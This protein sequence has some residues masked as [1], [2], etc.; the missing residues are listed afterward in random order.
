MQ[1][2]ARR[3]AQP[4]GVILKATRDT[5]V[6]AEWQR[7]KAQYSARSAWLRIPF[8]GSL[9]FC[10]LGILFLPP[11]FRLYVIA[12]TVAL[13]LLVGVYLSVYSHS[14]LTCPNCGK[15]QLNMYYTRVEHDH[16]REC[17]YWLEDLPMTPNNSPERT[18]D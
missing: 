3:S 12:V 14:S 2:R 8:Y 5:T 13:F 10:L 18:R 4:L 15:R 7:R 9:A 17:C 6:I 1:W 16:C 11:S